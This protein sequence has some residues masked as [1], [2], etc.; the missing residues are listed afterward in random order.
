MKTTLT[1]LALALLAV[2][3]PQATAEKE[4]AAQLL[5]RLATASRDRLIAKHKTLLEEPNGYFGDLLNIEAD[6]AHAKYQAHH[7]S[8]VPA[9]PIAQPQPTS[10]TPTSL[11]RP[12]PTHLPPDN[13]HET[14]GAL[15]LIVAGV[16]G[17]LGWAIYYSEREKKAGQSGMKDEGIG[18]VTFC[19]Q[20]ICTIVGVMAVW[21][22]IDQMLN[23]DMDFTQ[24][25]LFAFSVP[26][27]F[28][29][30][31]R[32]QNMGA[33]KWLAFLFALPIFC[34]V[35]WVLLALIPA[36]KRRDSHIGYE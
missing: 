34:V 35:G 28:L 13:P 4:T 11:P 18:R 32:L 16:L 20:L 14:S 15:G 19:I 6:R 22:A 12:E 31:L 30:L 2:M 17:T 33:P 8:A 29:V 25:T 1:L 21:I 26:P 27:V 24:F 36:R 9:T 10:Y 5:A 3:V 7:V 23:N